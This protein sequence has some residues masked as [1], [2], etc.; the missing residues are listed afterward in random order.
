MFLFSIPAELKEI[1]SL[2]KPIPF[3]ENLPI[4]VIPSPSPTFSEIPLRPM[5]TGKVSSHK[6]CAPMGYNKIMKFGIHKIWP[7]FFALVS[8][9]ISFN[10]F[11][12]TL[13]ATRSET[14]IPTAS[15]E[16]T[17]AGLFVIRRTD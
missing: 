6:S 16:A 14:V 13:S 7:L 10:G 3:I 15:I 1:R 5:A 12:P 4:G 8:K 9:Y 2:R 17:L 11:E